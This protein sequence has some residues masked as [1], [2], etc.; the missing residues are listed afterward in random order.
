VII[1]SISAIVTARKPEMPSCIGDLRLFTNQLC[2]EHDTFEAAMPLLT[3]GGNWSKSG[4][5]VRYL[6]AFLST[7]GFAFVLILGWG[8][9][10]WEFNPA[11]HF[12]AIPLTDDPSWYQNWNDLRIREIQDRDILFHNVGH[13]I[14]EARKADI[15]FIGH[16]MVLW[17]IRYD[18]MEEFARNNGLRIYNLASAGDGSGEFI[19][20]IIS[21]W[22][23][24]PKLW[25]INVDDVG[26]NKF[27]VPKLADQGNSGASSAENVVR[28]SRLKGTLNVYRRNVRW[29]IEAFLKKHLYQS[30][31]RVLLPGPGDV[32]WRSVTNGNWMLDKIGVYTAVTA[33]TVHPLVDP[34]CP[35]T[36]ENNALAAKYL[37]DI[38]GRSILTFFPNDGFCAQRVTDIASA[39]GVEALFTDK[40]DYTSHDGMHLDQRGATEFTR[41]FLERVKRSKT[42]RELFGSGPRQ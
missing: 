10:S 3:I 17:G 6:I 28:R 26:S 18:V 23:I 37:K 5:M 34:V 19:R 41:A 20:R 7:A 32:T 27:F 8:F 4:V 35:S 13:S 16:S 1:D 21:K 40:L 11:D 14:E 2:A 39:V 38:G 25:I 42:F 36:P 30:L 29:R 15:I 22:D 24:H 9:L 33:R 31:A 12:A